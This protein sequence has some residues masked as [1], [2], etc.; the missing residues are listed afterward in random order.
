MWKYT[1]GIYFGEKALK[2]P[3]VYFRAQKISKSYLFIN[4]S[5]HIAQIYF[6]LSCNNYMLFITREIIHIY[7]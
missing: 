3:T 7:I 6:Q 2:T 1:A 4:V 5:R